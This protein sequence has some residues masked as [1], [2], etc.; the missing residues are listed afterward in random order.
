[1]P[2]NTEPARARLGFALVT[3]VR[4]WRSQVENQLTAS[5]LTDATW[6]PLLH[7]R[8]SGDGVTQK[9][10]AQRVGLDGS[11]LVRL[12]DI[13]ESRGWV[14]RRTSDTDRRSKR[15]FLTE[16]GHATVQQL[17][18]TMLAVE[19]QLIQDLSDTEVSAL[20]GSVAKID[21]RLAQLR[22]ADAGAPASAG[23]SDASL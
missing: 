5:G 3:M 14:E 19:Y 13:L 16:A 17:R 2:K 1:M 10:L 23:S 4:R 15:I 11:S 12:L 7:L 21:Q 9:D 8:A 18:K 20:L 6:M 22:Q